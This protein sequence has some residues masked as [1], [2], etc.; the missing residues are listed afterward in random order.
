MSVDSL[1]YDRTTEDSIDF[2][3]ENLPEKKSLSALPS[4]LSFGGP[5]LKKG[6]QG[7]VGFLEKNDKNDNPKK[8][9]YKISQYLDFMAEQ[10]YNVM[11]DVNTLRD[12]CP[13]F[14]KGFGLV[15]IPITANYKKAKNPFKDNPDYKSVMAYIIIIMAIAYKCM[16]LERVASAGAV[17]GIAAC[18]VPVQVRL[19]TM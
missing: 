11:K 5:L 16:V 2:F 19:Q 12:Y 1:L 3:K 14:V 4:F 6:K 18:G 17:C 13:H 8:Y 9:V 7:L 15:R 10:E